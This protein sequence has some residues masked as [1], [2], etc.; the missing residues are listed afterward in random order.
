MATSNDFHNGMVIRKDGKL[1]VVVDF[2]HV[3]PGKGGAFVRSKLKEVRTG[4]VLDVTWRAGEKVD[5]VRLERHKA[6]F[7]YADDLY[8]FMKLDNYEQLALP[9]DVVGEDKARFLKEGAEVEMLIDGADPVIVELPN[10]VELR[11]VKTEPGMKGDTVSGGSKPATTE[12]G[13]V[14]QVPLFINEGETLRIDTRTGEYV[15]RV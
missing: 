10:F 12:T 7:L 3:K 15:S 6:Q 11:V 13:A 4:R 14:V 9:A 8:H 5:D 1:Y 2:L